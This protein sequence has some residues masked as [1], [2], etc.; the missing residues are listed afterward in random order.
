MDGV[1][2]TA[3][4]RP[5]CHQRRT[6]AAQHRLYKRFA[7]L[8]PNLLLVAPHLL[9]HGKLAAGMASL[10][11]EFAAIARTERARA[12]LSLPST[13]CRPNSYNP[14]RRGACVERDGSQ[15]HVRGSHF[16]GRK[17]LGWRPHG[18]M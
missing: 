6:V 3:A 8:L 14:K 10:H 13:P 15:L 11:A 5:Y 1:A 2:A 18:R 16:V 7:H 4:D 17:C 12:L 9:V